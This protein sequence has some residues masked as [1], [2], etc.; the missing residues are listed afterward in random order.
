[1]RCTINVKAFA[2][3][4][5]FATRVVPVRNTI[6]I[7]GNVKLEITGTSLAITGTDLDQQNVA[8]VDVP[9]SEPGATTV[10]GKRFADLI[11]RLP[12]DADVIMRVDDGQFLIACGR[13]RWKLPTLPAE[14]SPVLDP[15]GPDAA[16]FMLG[17]T[18]ARRL[19]RRVE[20][21]ICDEETRYYLN[22]V[23]LHRLDGKLVA[24]ATNGHTLA[25]TVI[26]LAP[27][28]DL[29]AIVP[30]KAI[31]F[32]DEMASHGGVEVRVDNQK[33]ALRA[34][35]YLIVSRLID[36][37]Y[38]DYQR[39]LP[40]KITNNVEIAAADLIASIARHTAA[41]ETDKTIGL[42]WADGMLST[43]LSRG[44]DSAV[45]ELDAVASSGTGRVA[46]SATYL[47]EAIQALDAKTIRIEHEGHGTPMRITAEP[48]TVMI[49]MPM[50]W[51]H[52][53]ED[54]QPVPP[55][56]KSRKK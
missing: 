10:P 1:M 33:I 34:G 16:V 44:G 32:L 5:K 43:C 26:D 37:T 55:A 6:P 54:D 28:L 14:D 4:L 15:P 40:G 23:Y 20:H 36:A 41:A 35:S 47:T 50:A 46:A 24:V 3:A 39:V 49:V 51:P 7:V 56:R 53:V 21:A 29:K 42:T 2:T 38:P 45:E 31:A 12:P 19:V 52:L 17:E 48:E 9:V 11:D 8:T 30:K 18:E 25:R 13:G 27:G 22:G